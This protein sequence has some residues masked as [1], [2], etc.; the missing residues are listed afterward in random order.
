LIGTVT[1]DFYDAVTGGNL[2]DSQAVSL[3][4]ETFA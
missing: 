4:A 2:L 3:Q 1:L